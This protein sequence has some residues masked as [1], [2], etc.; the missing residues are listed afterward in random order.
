[1]AQCQ[2]Y[3]LT[4]IPGE[5]GPS[6]VIVLYLPTCSQLSISQRQFGS[7]QAARSVTVP[8]EQECVCKISAL[9]NYVRQW[10]EGFGE[11]Y[12]GQDKP[13]GAVSIR[14]S[15]VQFCFEDFNSNDSGWP[16]G[17]TWLLPES[18]L[19]GTWSSSHGVA[20][21]WTQKISCNYIK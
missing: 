19:L 12:L 2:F 14:T 10:L 20:I 15:F 6:Q 18:E 1:M 3:D 13:W 9:G 16:L 4:F 8:S 7:F 21:S 11:E 5:P 17:K